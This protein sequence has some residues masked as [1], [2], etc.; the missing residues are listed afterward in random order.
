MSFL[1]LF[2]E[3]LWFVEE[4][5]AFEKN[6]EKFYEIFAKTDFKF[7]VLTNEILSMTAKKA[8]FTLH[9][10]V[11]D[12]HKNK[13][14]TGINN[15]AYNALG[16]MFGISQLRLPQESSNRIALLLFIWFWLIFRTC[17]Q[18]KLF[19]FMT[20][21]MRKPMPTSINDLSEMNYTIVLVEGAEKY[22]RAKKEIIN[23]RNSPNILKVTYEDFESFYQSALNVHPKFKS[24]F[25]V[26]NFH[27]AVLN[28]TFKNSLTIM[29]NEKLSK[30]VGYAVTKNM[31]LFNHLNFIISQL[32]PTGIAKNQD[33]YGLWFNFRPFDI[34]I[35]DPRRI[36][37]LTDLEFGF[38]LWLFSL[39]LPITC[40]LCEILAGIFKKIKSNTKN[41]ILLKIFTSVSK[42]II[43]KH[44][45]Q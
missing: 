45:I 19:E 43:E 22:E 27:H 1:M 21:D 42:K 23:E 31:F 12:I 7:Q 40:F 44:Q 34:E 41:L 18:S 26:S 13:A 35:V 16:S 3:P 32:I 28:S 36:L 14:L 5:K 20:T 39:S 38:F 11:T 10:T 8:N 15:P 6:V 2:G 37:S 30:S 29:S 25:L 33:N 17:Y 4:Y 9:Y 24:A